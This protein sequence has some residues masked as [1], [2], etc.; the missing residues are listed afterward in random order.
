MHSHALRPGDRFNPSQIFIGSFIPNVLMRFTGLSDGAKLAWARLNQ[1]AG[2]DGICYPA[3]ATLAKELGKSKRQVQ[4][5]LNELEEK[6]F[7]DRDAPDQEAKGRRETTHYYFTWHTIFA[8]STTRVTSVPS[9]RPPRDISVPS[10]S[11]PRDTSDSSPR[12][13]SV[14]PLETDVSPKENQRKQEEN[15]TTI[16]NPPEPQPQERRDGNGCGG[17]LSDDQKRVIELTIMKAQAESK[18]KSSPG[19][20]R[21]SLNARAKAGQLDTSDLPFLES[22]L[23]RKEAVDERRKT[24]QSILARR[25]STD[26][27]MADRDE[28]HKQ[29]V[30]AAIGSSGEPPSVWIQRVRKAVKTMNR[31]FKAEGVFGFTPHYELR[32][33]QELYPDAFA[34]LSGGDGYGYDE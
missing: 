5:V 11:T 10:P 31:E 17:F 26:R 6:G 20:L 22:W 2:H 15:T 7:I 4:R 24:Q 19:A 29:A 21:K 25:A 28:A 16:T 27:Q 9:P 30:K 32:I 12:D 18:I 14:A 8:E 33:M 34:L 3:L 1:Y 23:K 13:T